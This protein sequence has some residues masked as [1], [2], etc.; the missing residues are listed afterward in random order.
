MGQKPTEI[1]YQQQ[2]LDK[3]KKIMPMHQDELFNRLKMVR[4]TVSRLHDTDQQH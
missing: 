2:A 4:S 3:P 1:K